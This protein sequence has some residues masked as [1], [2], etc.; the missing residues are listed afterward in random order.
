MVLA[1]SSSEW[2]V[3]ENGSCF[4]SSSCGEK[5]GEK[6]EKHGVNARK[7]ALGEAAGFSRRRTGRNRGFVRE[8]GG[9]SRSLEGAVAS[10][11]GATIDKL[12]VKL[13]LL[14][15]LPRVGG[16]ARVD[17]VGVCAPERKILTAVLWFLGPNGGF[18]TGVRGRGS[19]IRKFGT[20][21]IKACA[22]H[23]R[24]EGLSEDRLR[25]PR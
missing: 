14:T 11:R 23:E 10:G 24:A 5:R 3:R 21:G 1:L 18:G 25:R 19:G 8:N 12:A 7:P 9:A 17:W 15:V 4:G 6:H 22:R 13:T 20:I 16:P 2:R